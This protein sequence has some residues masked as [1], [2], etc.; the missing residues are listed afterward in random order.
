MAAE[1]VTLG[2]EEEYQIID[3]ET[4]RLKPRSLP[5]L[6][7]A[8]A[9]LGES[10]QPE[11]HASQIEI[12]T[13][14]CKSL[15]EVRQQLTDSRR[16]LLEATARDGHRI[17]A[18]ATHPFSHSHAQPITDKPRYLDMAQ[19]YKAL[20][21]ELVIFGCHVHVG[22][23]DRE[24][25]LVV[26]N[27][28]RPW[29]ATLLALSASS[30]F[31]AGSDTGYASYRTELWVRWPMAGPPLSFASLA[32]HDALVQSLVKTGSISSETKIYWDVRL[33]KH[34]P[35]IEFRVADVCPTVDEAVMI[36]GLIQAL[37]QTCHQQGQEDIMVPAIR[38]EVLRAAHWRAA[39]YGLEG[40]L[41]DP[42][43]ETS[44]PATEMVQRLLTLVRPALEASGD[45]SEVSGL[46]EKTLTHGNSAM[47]QRAV[48]ARTGRLEDVVDLLTEETAQGVL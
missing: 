43:A 6:H 47:R 29:L 18:A 31:W 7:D 27:R 23:A 1:D 44:L 32:E 37:V 28:A 39:R 2:V 41:V 8:E 24:D 13:P 15:T 20:A 19:D 30:P 40:E 26:L 21:D 12:A 36:A 14:V 3:P 38:H 33:P 35:T 17:V 16:A 46:V 48:Y 42:V 5:I 22:I 25:A 45:W 34:V 9:A 11:F 4:R 10:V